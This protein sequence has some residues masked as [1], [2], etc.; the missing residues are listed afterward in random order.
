MQPVR[1][2]IAA[3][4]RTIIENYNAAEPFASFFPGVAGLRGIPLWVFYVNRGQCVSSFGVQNRNAAMLDFASANVAY[5]D[6]PRL[7]FRTFLKV[8]RGSA[9][10][11]FYEPFRPSRENLDAGVENRLEFCPAFLRLHE[12]NPRLGLEVTVTFQTVPGE[13]FPA[14]ARRVEVRNLSDQ[15]AHLEWVDGLPWVTCVGI[16]LPTA[17]LMTYTSKSWILVQGT[18][19][20]MPYFQLRCAMSDSVD[21]EYFD[22]G[23]FALHL[24]ERGLLG[25]IVDP[26]AVFGPDTAFDLPQA[27]LAADDY[28]L[29]DHQAVENQ[30]PSAMTFVRADLGPKQAKSLL[31]VYGQ[32]KG[33]DRLAAIAATV[34][35]PEWFGEKLAANARIAA[36]LTNPAQ[37]FSAD[38]TY[39]AYVRHTF[40]DNALRGGLPVTLPDASGRRRT[41]HVFSRIHGDM[42]RDYN[43]FQ[44]EPAF[45]SQ[46]NGGYRDVLQN[47]RHDVYANPD[48]GTSTIRAFASLLRL[49][50]YNPHF[51]LG[52]VFTLRGD[53][54]PMG[55]IA[56]FVTNESDAQTVIGLLTPHF[57]PGKILTALA[58]RNIP[59]R[60]EPEDLLA[61]LLAASERE[62]LVQPVSGFWSDHWHYVLDAIDSFLSV[63][64][65]RRRELLLGE[66]TYPYAHGPVHVR[67][68]SERYV[69]RDGQ[70]FQE[71]FLEV[72][73][74]ARDDWRPEELL[75]RTQHGQGEPYRTTLFAKLLCVATLKAATLDPLGVGVEFEAG[76]PNWNDSLNGLPGIFGSSS[77]ETLELLRLV[78]MLLDALEDLQPAE[79]RVHRELADLLAAIAQASADAPG[80]TEG[81]LFAFWDA[82]NT[83]KEA[84]RTATRQG[85]SG[86]EQALAPD[87]VAGFL[88]DVRD[89]LIGGIERAMDPRTHLIRGYFRHEMTEYDTRTEGARTVIVPKAFAQIPLAPFLEAPMHYLRVISDAPAAQRQYDAVRSSP[90][91]DE[92][93]G[94]YKVSA[95]LAGEPHRIGR[96]CIF[97]PGWL[98]NESIWLHMEYKYLLEVLRAGLYEEF[99][100]DLRSCL[101]AWQPPERYGRSPLENSS[102]LVCSANPNPQLHGQGFYARLS[103]AT[104]E[105]LDMHRI[106][107]FGDR[108][109]GLDDAGEL[110]LTLQPVLPRWLFAG[111]PRTAR[112]IRNGQPVETPLPADHYA[113][114][115]F[116]RTLVAYVNPHRKDT[117][118]G[119]RGVIKSAV[120]TTD[121]G[122][123]FE[124]E[125]EDLR[126]DIARGIRDGAF[127]SVIVHLE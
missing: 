121:D 98:E 42:E 126:G 15:P 48:V 89:R 118:G 20:R 40:L 108:P 81:E 55:A 61:E 105:F 23:N 95:S 22:R 43:A 27:F 10:A 100:A 59:L 5:R 54:D 36:E 41:F 25:A 37:T 65:D 57:T 113:T 46:G 90:L 53:T 79:V 119:N 93:L 58:Q 72:E 74:P 67:P 70:P 110:T 86:Q 11:A 97:S 78:E 94:M 50:A 13:L 76:R 117:F 6:T 30:V 64:P 85:V 63:Y 56:R 28:A 49:D 26:A 115:L 68:R 31:G 104:A 19:E 83:A 102:F 7:G 12:R 3:D 38:A 103:G 101:V 123:R 9:P 99:F 39:D 125:P 34:T 107:S 21:L 24:D 1:Y 66:A 4:G 32:A 91:Y 112:W 75:A 17:R 33:T 69:L 96:I 124:L 127:A 14:L 88:R 8:R 29:P 87:G 120:L 116:N 44:L 51:L 80:Q 45:W 60:G 114:V 2:E 106:M 111:E 77:C 16:D 92:P 71:N 62:E 52:T 122:Q 109:F 47:R 35:A 84:Y 18:R 82:A 73:G